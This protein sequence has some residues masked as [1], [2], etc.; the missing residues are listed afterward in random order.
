MKLRFFKFSQFVFPSFH[1]WGLGRKSII[2]FCTTW[3]TVKMHLPKRSGSPG[4][5]VTE[6]FLSASWWHF[7]QLL[8][9]WYQKVVFKSWKKNSPNQHVLLYKNYNNFL[10]LLIHLPPFLPLLFL[11]PSLCPLW[12]RVL[13]C[14]LHRPSTQNPPASISPVL[15]S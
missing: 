9:V 4:D 1:W 8:V 7:I 10:P 12:G 3:S 2:Y 15:G 5:W 13:L 14:S 6:I 11:F